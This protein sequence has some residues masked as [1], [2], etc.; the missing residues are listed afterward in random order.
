MYDQF[1]Y[2]CHQDPDSFLPTILLERVSVV[3]VSGWVIA[4]SGRCM[5]EWDRWV[6]ERVG[7]GGGWGGG[8][9]GCGGEWERWVCERVG[10]VGGWVSWRG[11]CVSE[12]DR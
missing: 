4:W 12:W 11:W 3:E 5:G 6:C 7:E 10:E 1:E 9:G 2:E 8:R